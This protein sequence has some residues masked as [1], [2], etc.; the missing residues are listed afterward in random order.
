MILTFDETNHIYR[1]D[2]V[3]IP[4]YSEISRVMGI[5]DYGDV[6]QYFLEAARKFGQAGHYATRLWD[7]KTLNEE[8]LSSP[9][10]P[11]LNEYKQFLRDYKVEILPQYTEKPICSFRYRYGVTPDRVCIIKGELSILELKFVEVM[12]PGT[13]IQTAAQKLAVEEYHKIKIKA[14]YGLQIPLNGK[15]RPCFYKDKS[16]ENTWLCFLGAYNWRIKNG[17]CN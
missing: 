8:T 13:A 15:C 17:K 14:R 6:P 3:Q 1:L 4:S 12:K 16:D 9:L 11:C 5:V 7:N 2:G 10:I